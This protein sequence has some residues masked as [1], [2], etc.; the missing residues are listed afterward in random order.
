MKKSRL[1]DQELL[2]NTA[3][4]V[5]AEQEDVNLGK[6]ILDEDLARKNLA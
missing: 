4:L 1:L 2:C 3:V 5:D 6:E